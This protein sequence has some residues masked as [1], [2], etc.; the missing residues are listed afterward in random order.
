MQVATKNVVNHPTSDSRKPQAVSDRLYRILVRDLDVAWS[1]GVFDHEYERVQIVRINLELQAREM[2]D[3]NCDD[4]TQVV[5]YAD[6]SERI[7]VLAAEGHIRLVETLAHKIGLLC[8]EDP[9]VQEAVVRVEKPEALK[10]AQTVG[11]EVTRT[12]ADVD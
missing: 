2:S 10:N 12:R 11:V 8:L 5:C 3:P 7:R 9:R 6:I 1:I 4:Y